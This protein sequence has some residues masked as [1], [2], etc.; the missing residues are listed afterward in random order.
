[1]EHTFSFIQR[2]GSARNNVVFNSKIWAPAVQSVADPFD[3]G[4][5][6]PIDG[7]APRSKTGIASS[8]T[9]DACG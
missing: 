3:L 8:T 1:M 7:V 9:R 2:F 4:Y 5:S 6:R